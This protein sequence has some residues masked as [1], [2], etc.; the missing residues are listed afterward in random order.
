MMKEDSWLPGFSHF[1]FSSGIKTQ[2]GILTCHLATSCVMMG[3]LISSC[4]M[5]IYMMYIP[6]GMLAVCST[7]IA[8]NKKEERVF[9]TDGRFWHC[10]PARM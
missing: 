1:Q 7:V 3:L 2:M 8:H 4:K 5:F 9:S 6:L 10:L